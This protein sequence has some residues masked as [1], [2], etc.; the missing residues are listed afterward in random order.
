[1]RHKF[2]K[3]W[4]VDLD[5]VVYPPEAGKY[6]LF[7]S[8]QIIEHFSYIVKSVKFFLNFKFNYFSL[9]LLNYFLF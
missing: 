4:N 1:M 9:F 2:L 5:E 8:D 7:S 3:N 6:S